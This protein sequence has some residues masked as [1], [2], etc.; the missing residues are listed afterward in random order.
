MDF[1]QA[2]IR[3]LSPSA[4]SL[5]QASPTLWAMRYL[6]KIRD[7]DDA[8]NIWRG[9]AVEAAVD[10]ALYGATEEEAIK[11]AADNFELHAQGVVDDKTEVIRKQVPRCVRSA[12]KA[13]NEPERIPAPFS[14]QLKIEAWVDGVSVPLI[15]YVDYAWPE[16]LFDLKAPAKMTTKPSASHVMQIA[17]YWKA[18]DRMP[19]LLYAAPTGHYWY[20]P[21]PDE[22][23]AAWRQVEIGARA[24]SR[25]LGKVESADDA[26]RMFLPDLDNFRWS[27]DLRTKYHRLMAA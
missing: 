16:W 18:T 14:R 5:Y 23:E 3:N 26:M 13:I 21:E 17:T 6:H 11:K 12:L 1:D 24:I 9:R 7:D 2:S 25:M 27:D 19:K 10:V 20:S 8:Q 4:I 22:L 15:G